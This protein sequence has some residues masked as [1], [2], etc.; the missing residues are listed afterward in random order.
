MILP[1]FTKF[2]LGQKKNAP[3]L[4]QVN[5]FLIPCLKTLTWP[6]KP[7]MMWPPPSFPVPSL[8]NVHHIST[9]PSS[10]RELLFHI[11]KTLLILFPLPEN[12][13]SPFPLLPTLAI[14]WI[15]ANAS[16]PNCSVPPPL[17]C[18]SPHP[19]RAKDY[20]DPYL[21]AQLRAFIVGCYNCLLTHFLLLDVQLLENKDFISFKFLF[22][23]LGPE[24]SRGQP[25]GLHHKLRVSSQ[26]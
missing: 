4:Q 8:L 7:F 22:T 26:T 20:L 5:S 13:T 25:K 17:W 12:V 24:V 11:S 2:N 15:P 6:A 3:V 14:S 9:L 16:K 10:Q 23:P 19:V 18:P 21:P 1:R